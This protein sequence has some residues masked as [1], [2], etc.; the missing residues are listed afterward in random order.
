MIKLGI[1]MGTSTI[2]LVLME[3][4]NIRKTWLGVHYG[5]VMETLRRGLS[6]MELPEHFMAAVT[7]SNRLT[8]LDRFPNLTQTEE[9]P[10]ATMGVGF[11]VPE[12]GSIMDIGSQNARFITLLQDKAPSFSVNEHCAGGTGSF[13]EDQM[14]RL[15]LKIE[16]YSK[17]VESAREVPRL[18]GRCA[19]FAKT[20]IIHRQQEGVLKQDILLGLCYAMIRNYKAVIVKSLPVEKPVVFCGGV[21][22][23]SGVVRAIRD[24]FSLKETEL[25]IPEKARFTGAVG[26]ALSAE[27]TV[28]GTELLQALSEKQESFGGGTMLPPLCLREYP[29]HAE[30]V[31]TGKIPA[32]GCSLGIDIGSTSTDLVLMGADGSLL[33]FQYLRTAGNPEGVVR[34]G[35]KNIEERF[36]AVHIL[37]VGVTGSGRER[38]GRMMGADAVRDEITAQARAASFWAP[39]VDTVFEIGGQDSKY[40]SLKN[41]Q[42]VDFQMNKICAAG[43][44]SFVEEQAA[45][46]GI[47]ISEFGELA[48]Q[49]KAP[50]ELSE[51]CTVF[52]ETA[53]VQA[54]AAGASIEDI[55]AGLCH[56]IVKNYLY[57]VV[58]N[59]PVGRKIVLQGG[60]AYNPGIVAAF[61][62]AYGERISVSPVFAISGACGAALLAKE[63]VGERESSFLGF[64]FPADERT[65]T[66]PDEEIRKNRAFYKKAGQMI[67]SD[68]SG[69]REP[70]KKTIG[71]PLSLIVFKFFPMIQAFFRNLGYNVILSRP[72]NEETIRLSQQYARSETC[73]PVKLLYGHMAQLA[74]E[75]VDYIFMPLIRTIHHPHSHAVHNYACPYMQR[76]PRLVY[77]TLELDKQGIQLLSPVLDLDLGKKSMAE[78]MLGAGKELGFGKAR[79]LPGLVKGA[80]AVQKNMEDTEELGRKLLASLKPQDKVL[81]LITRNYGLAD[82]V[83]NMG[84]PEL[85]L[86]QGYKVI[87]LAHLP[88]MSLDLS[89]D[90]PHMYWPFG[91][92]LLSGAKLIANH[93]QLYAVYLTNHGCGPDTLVAHMFKEEMGDK[94]YLHI[95][96]DEH[97]SKVGI[98][99]RIEAFLNSI[100]HRSPVKMPENFDIKQVCFRKA[101]LKA[102]PV[103]ERILLLP[104]LGPATGYLK[105]YFERRGIETGQMPPFDGESLRLGRAE[106]TSKEYLPFPMLVGSCLRAL[107]TQPEEK[108]Q[109]LIPFN[110]GADAD[111]QYARAVRTVL[112]R[113]GYRN[114]D[115]IA[116]MLEE[117]PNSATDISGLFHAVLAGDIAAA[118]PEEDREKPS[119][120]YEYEELIE[121][122]KRAGALGRQKKRILAAVGDPL[123]VTSLNEGILKRLEQEDNRVTPMPL[124]EM[125]LFLWMDNGTISADKLKKWEAEL[126]DVSGYMGAASPF[127]PSLAALREIADRFLPAYAGNHGR[128]RFAKAISMGEMADAVLLL[129]P[130][131]EN[132]ATVLELSSL[133]SRC[134]APLFSISLDGDWD[135]SSESR[136]RSFL[137]YC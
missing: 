44:G 5:Q 1:D 23:N 111:G 61:Q 53:I 55:S 63:A 88:G 19:V 91:D 64:D 97:Y 137:Y 95:E 96:V 108:L 82:P 132:T 20:D 90:Y 42:V 99:T 107:E 123:C 135:E 128:Y 35:L 11:L 14:S 49:G 8:L 29:E 126:L 89:S 13:F 39:D 46:M 40:I 10:A 131:Y 67:T 125:L 75:K 24:V 21:T 6:E 110:Y 71:V 30:P 79:C 101:N 86:R 16:D 57:K 51:R 56:A 31:C 83:L 58:A 12:T 73:Y 94:P 47:P 81:V 114:V 37:G 4:Q 118:L 121:M 116:P 72:S 28:S 85:L 22:C 119:A 32:E 69:V 78:A 15:G 41:G 84:I 92:H 74:A 25:I 80:V 109:F 77:E 38:I 26:A 2:K 112:D 68:Y 18:S 106:T 52:I 124:S 87:T 136:L 122:A 60:V 134:S 133:N 76:A 120:L 48:L 115:I 45:R 98:I 130:R 66:V 34:Q 54:E 113:R 50:C 129:S 65:E 102:A 3:E 127:A 36:G 70:G 17:L 93:P 100:S 104:D 33:D 59:K 105:Y 117:I 7:G 103:K 43:T 62:S 27:Q 9:I